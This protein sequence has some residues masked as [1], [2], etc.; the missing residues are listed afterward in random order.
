MVIRLRPCT[1]WVP[2]P[3]PPPL[4]FFI[5]NSC[6]SHP[7]GRVGLLDDVAEAVG[8]LDSV[9]L[10]DAKRE[11]RH[12]LTQSGARVGAIGSKGGAP[13]PPPP[14]PSAARTTVDDWLREYLS[15]S[16]SVQH[17]LFF[18]SRYIDDQ[19]NNGSAAGGYMRVYIPSGYIVQIIGQ[20]VQYAAVDILLWLGFFSITLVVLALLAPWWHMRAACSP[21]SLLRYGF[22]F[23]PSVP[24]LARVDSA[25]AT[26]NL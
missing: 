16:Q 17:I 8:E 2:P 18:V 3:P 7:W 9:A 5:Y 26:V 4:H 1:T 14:P 21:S 15:I 20:L 23:G 24:S 13:P 19:Y 12:T 22:W 6:S 25:Q 10:L 11:R